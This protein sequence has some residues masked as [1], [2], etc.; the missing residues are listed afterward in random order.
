LTKI[1]TDGK[2]RDPHQSKKF[3]KETKLFKKAMETVEV[4]GKFILQ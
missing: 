3:E 1:D 4:W 2:L